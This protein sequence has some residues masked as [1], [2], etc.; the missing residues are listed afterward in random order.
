MFLYLGSIVVGAVLLYW[1]YVL[2]KGGKVGQATALVVD[3]QQ[4]KQQPPSSSTL[5]GGK[6]LFP[7]LILFGSQTGTAE[8]YAKTLHREGLQLGVQNR[9]QDVEDYSHDSLVDETVV[10]FVVATYGEGEPTDAMKP[11]YDWL[12]DGERQ[13]DEMRN[14]KYTVFGLGDGQYKF[15]CQMGVHVDER[16]A[17]LG[18]TRIF[19]LGCGDAGKSMEEEFDTWRT[20]LW[21]SIGSSL[22][23]VLKADTEE[24]L[25]PELKLKY[26][27]VPPS[28][29]P[30]PKAAS[31][32]EPTQKLPVYGVV[33][34]NR[35][36]LQNCPDRSTHHV[37]IDISGTL[38]SYQAGDHLGILSCNTDAV[39]DSYLNVLKLDNEAANKGISLQDKQFKNIFPSRASI[40]TVLK[41]YVDLSGPPKKSALRALAH[42]CMDAK[43]KEDLLSLLRVNHEAAERYRKLQSK[44]RTVF[45]FLRKYSS[46]N[47]PIEIFLEVM[48]RMAPRYFSIASDQLSQP[49]QIFITVAVVADGVCTSMLSNSAV[50]DKIPLFVR[51]SNFHLPLRSKNRALI[52]IGPGTGVAPLVGFCHR[53]T[54][55]KAKGNEL[56]EAMLFFGC[57]KAKEDFLYQDV[58]TD[59]LHRGVLSDLD[60]AFSREQEGKVYVQ[61]RLIEKAKEVWRIISK[62]HGNV[63]ICG[64]AKHMAKEVEEVLVNIVVKEGKM[65]RAQ[66][67]KF[68]EKMVVEERYLKDVWSA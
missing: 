21:P 41:W 25:V 40:R 42:Y 24:P 15:F 34:E 65:E 20:Q 1:L 27:E 51:K 59:N 30:F 36:L 3:H 39:V 8:L 47:V 38:I 44:V 56:G 63:Y 10:V 61:H 26:V 2:R 50:G 23:I 9:L 58:L 66:A 12:M 57:R 16:M 29:L 53:R 45:G 32:L 5:A 17:K 14:V 4:Q 35:E 31:A 19:G 43:E 48:P 68:L 33:V 11:F 54:A 22:G 62:E 67:D 28:S 52:L 18:A 37:A 49:T 64:D 46:C 55:W 6:S 60:V 7:V 13:P